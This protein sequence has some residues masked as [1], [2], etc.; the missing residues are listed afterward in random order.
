MS[1]ILSPKKTLPSI[2]AARI[3]HWAMLLGAHQYVIE[4]RPAN[5]HANVDGLS[6]LP[7]QVHNKTT[8]ARSELSLHRIDSVLPITCDDIAS[9]TRNDPLLSRVYL[10]TMNGWNRADEKD[11]DLKP[12]HKHRNEINTI[13]GVLT[14]GSRVIVPARFHNKIMDII[15][16][17][18]LG[19]SKMKAIARGYV[20]WPGIDQQIEQK[21]LGCNGCA[22][23]R[24]MPAASPL[25]PWEW[26]AQPWRRLH[27]DFAGPFLNRMF[28]VVVDAHS[29]WPEVIPMKNA[30][31]TT[32][33]TAL[34]SIF[35][36]FGLPDQ[37]VSDN[38]ANLLPMNSKISFVA[39]IFGI[40]HQHPTT[41]LPMGLPNALYRHLNQ[42]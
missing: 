31:S 10:L 15:H 36:R 5:Q 18:H 42:P 20:Y 27:I 34:R 13:N 24:K 1:H 8:A 38:E 41:Q 25:H 23:T 21:A 4:H 39:T 40:L 33:I 29:K 28:L 6:R 2:A 7:V 26:P 30:T 32:T 22:Q 19:M 3:Q 16:E 14:Y 37:I 12:Y 9:E 11:E 35:S 17:G